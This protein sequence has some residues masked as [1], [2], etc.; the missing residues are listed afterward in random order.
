MLALIERPR[1]YTAKKLASNYNVDRS[2]IRDDIIAL[3][4]AGLIVDRDNKDRYFLVENKPLKKL[5]DLLH[6]SEED[7]IILK[8]AI[9]RI[10][11]YS[12]RRKKLVK[13]LSALYD[14]RKLGHA[15]LR[16]PYLSKVDL[17]LQA[18]DE[19][20]QVI[21]EQYRSASRIANRHVEAF[22]I[23]PPEDTLQ[24]FDI[25][26]KRIKHYRISRIKR[27]KLLNTYWQYEGHHNIMRTDPFRIVDNNQVMVH[28]RMGVGA[29][30]EL[31]ERFPLTRSYLEETEEEDKFDFQCL[32]NHKFIGLTNFILGF[33]HHHIEVLE[34]E[35]LLVHLR[36][37]VKKM[38][39]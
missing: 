6:F 11:P 33:H 16:K 32:V 24:A 19:H 17:L 23:N 36:E 27:V 5:K 12:E 8:D 20:L 4:E 3:G 26:A 14:Y 29:Y 31:T 25:E 34:P 13:K 30:N 38:N 9:E 37:Q 1:I 35:S 10:D 7:Q 28:L 2:T 22:H 15:Y 18:K 39:F 21:L